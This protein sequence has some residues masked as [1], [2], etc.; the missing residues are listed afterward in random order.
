MTV[1]QTFKEGIPEC[2]LTL[3]EEWH[4]SVNFVI[5]SMVV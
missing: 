1:P 3:A 5:T 2:L 4:I